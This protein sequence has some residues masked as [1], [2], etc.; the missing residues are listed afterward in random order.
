MNEEKSSSK[1]VPCIFFFILVISVLAWITYG[2]LEGVFGMLSYII[3]GI[4][5]LFPWII[6]FI[7]IPLGI[8][9]IF[10][11]F[12]FNIYEFSLELAHLESSWMSITWYWIISII[13][14][15]IDLTISAKIISWIRVQRKKEPRKNLALINCNIIDGNKDSE[16]L[17]NGII[18]IKNIV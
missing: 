2:T 9:E 14:I 7:G 4:I 13:G 15:I 6:P 17:Q 8:L 1:T 10:G 16:I 3:I 12:N 18:L 5:A 11:F